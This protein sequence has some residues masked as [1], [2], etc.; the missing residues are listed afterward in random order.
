[1]MITT[2]GNVG[3][4]NTAPGAKLQIEGTSDQL[5]LTYTSI[6]SYIHEVHSNGDYSVS[7]DSS[8][9]F[10]ILSAGQMVI[11]GTSALDSDKQLTLTTT[12]TSGGLGILSPNNG[13]GDIFFGDAADDNVGQ[14]KYSHVDDSLTIRTNAADRFTI[15]SSGNVGIN[16]AATT[17]SSTKT[18]QITDSTTARMLFESTGTGGRKYGWYTSVD[19]QF[20]VYDY[21]A[22]SE[23]FR[24]TSAGSVGVNTTNPAAK[25]HTV[26]TVLHEGDVEIRPESTG[27]EGG[28][29]TLKNPDKTSTGATIDVSS[30]NAFRIFQLNNNSI[31]EL[32]QLGGTGGIVKFATAGSERL[33]IDSSGN[34]AIGKTSASAKLDV[35]G[36]VQFGD[37]GGFDMNINGTRH[38]FSI[39]GSEKMRIDSSG[40]VGIG[41]TSAQAKL[42]VRT[43]ATGFAQFA[44]ASGN[45]GVRITGE[46]GSSNANLVFSNNRGVS[47]SDEYTIQL[48]GADDALVFRSGGPADTERL[49]ITSSGNLGVGTSSPSMKVNISHADQDGL[50]FNSAASGETFIDFAD[51]DDNDIGRISY[52]HSDNHMAFRTNNGERLRI[53]NAGN[54]GIGSTNPVADLVVSNGGASGIELQPEIATN[55]NRITNFNRSASSYNNF[56]LDAA[57]HEFLIS[58]SEKARIDSAGDVQARRSRSNTAG[59]VALSIQPS[60]ST[61]HYGFRIDQANN[62]F[63][64]DRVNNNATLLTVDGS[65]N[66]GIGV[67]SPSTKLQLPNQSTIRFG[68]SSAAPKAD[69]SYSSTGFEFL[70]IKCQGTTTG[71]GN[72]RFYTGATPTERMLIDSSGRLLVGAISGSYDFE[73]KKSGHIHGLIGSTNAA[74]ATL[75]LDG[76]SNGDG[77][78]SDYASVSHNSDGNLVFEN[79]KSASIIFRNTSSS[80]DR[81]QIDSSGRLLVGTSSTSQSGTVVFQGSSVS[82]SANADLKLACDSTAPGDGGNLAI[83]KFTDGTHVDGARIYA[84]R[85]GGTWSSSSKPTRILFATAANGSASPTERLR[86]DSAGRVGIGDDSPDALLVIKGNSDAATT[87]SIRLKDGTDTREAWITNASGDLSLNVGGNDNVAHGTFKMFESGILDYAQGSSS[88]LRMDSSGN[89]GINS[90]SPGEKLDVVGQIRARISDNSTGAFLNS[91][92]ALEVYRS[93][94]DAYIDFKSSTSEDFDVRLQQDSNGLRVL[95]GGNGATSEA[96]RVDSSGRLLV[97]TSTARTAGAGGHAELQ[98]KS[99]SSVTTDQVVIAAKFQG[100]TSTASSECLISCSAGYDISANDTEGQALFGAVREGTGNQAGFIVKTG[101]SNTERLRIASDGKISIGS[102]GDPAAANSNDPKVRLMPGEVSVANHTSASLLLN[103]TGGNGAVAKFFRDGGDLSGKITVTTS[104]TSYETSSDYRLKENVV[105]LS[106]GITRVKQLAPKRFNFIIDADT[107]VDGFLAH[108]AQAVVPEAVSGERDGEEMQG[109]DQSKLVPLLTAALQ[110][111]IA[112]IETLEQRLTDAGL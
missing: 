43:G 56:R 111:A 66:V 106:D 30:A 22:S 81:M 107:T 73:V 82:D 108:E 91:D 105:E 40:N 12:S 42:D 11:G 33:R 99:P 44:H 53:N 71:Y 104:S 94:G 76:D 72:I 10:R 23:R 67:S 35:N 75:L 39:G 112:K 36:N 20:A 103:R 59:D 92:G 8:E 64:L 74:G 93:G 57:Q 27:G 2:G 1:M 109:I 68:S 49:R 7:K 100:H 61:I 50:R 79:R 65:G 45:G 85:D 54:V 4:G 62:S 63:N 24:I 37:G 46:G 5:K 97:G 86:I 80:T 32:G 77:A 52:D 34:V 96:V 28:Q 18:L 89:V 60:D 3:I 88:R 9:R 87:P 78:G 14:I 17:A 84:Q 98:V 6:A 38:Q 90:T 26:G 69:I 41:T 48:S 110:E 25:L 29:I 55:T 95:T 31:M 15:D 102:T 58:G 47:T 13:R 51:P 16:G 19:G 101:T 21:T 83:I 70:D